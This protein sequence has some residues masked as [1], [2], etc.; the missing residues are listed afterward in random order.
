[1]EPPCDD[2]SSAV[3]LGAD[4]N[5]LADRAARER[6]PSESARPATESIVAGICGIH[7]A[8]VGDGRGRSRFACAPSTAGKEL[9][10]SRFSE[11]LKII[12]R[13]AWVVG[14]VCYL[15]V[16]TLALTVFIPG[17]KEMK[18]WPFA[19]KIAF[20]YGMFLF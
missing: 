7:V 5:E 12:P 11:A 10:M 14:A 4:A 19:G 1:M 18:Y 15:G 9:G 6:W 16:A 13:T 20:A 2:F 17:D 8:R 3:C